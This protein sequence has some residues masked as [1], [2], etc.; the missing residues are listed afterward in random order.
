MCLPRLKDS[1]FDFENSMPSLYGWNNARTHTHGMCHQM[2]VMYTYHAILDT[3]SID[4]S[5]VSPL[6]CLLT[7][8]KRSESVL[9]PLHY[10]HFEPRLQL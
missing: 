2:N 3:S 8:R 6:N 1:M 5:A 10:H 9:A 4:Q 7:R